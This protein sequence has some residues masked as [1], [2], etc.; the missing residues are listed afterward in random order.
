MTSKDT[1]KKI[2]L[3]RLKTAKTLLNADDWQGSAYMMGLALECMLKAVICKTLRISNYPERHKDKKIPDFFMTH[4]FNRL[5]LVSG[6]SD[7]FSPKGDVLAFGNWSSFVI[8]Y[9]TEWTIMRYID[10]SDPS[11]SQFDN[12]NVPDL[13]KYLYEDQNSIIKTIQRE[14]RC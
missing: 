2:A 13:Y 10:P 8:Q 11:S 3:I 1:L 14:Q 5:L 7:I 4:S 6:L 9:P 12:Q